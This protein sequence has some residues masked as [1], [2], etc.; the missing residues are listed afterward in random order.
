MQKS[1][2]FLI[3]T[4]RHRESGRELKVRAEDSGKLTALSGFDG[5]FIWSHEFEKTVLQVL[6]GKESSFELLRTGAGIAV[7]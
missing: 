7:G 4:L 2:V 5:E 1:G 6:D 3:H